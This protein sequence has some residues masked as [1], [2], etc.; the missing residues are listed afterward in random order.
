MR[1]LGFLKWNNS[2][3]LCIDWSSKRPSQSIYKINEIFTFWL[4]WSSDIAIRSFCFLFFL[5]PNDAKSRLRSKNSREKLTLQVLK[6]MRSYAHR[7]LVQHVC[8]ILCL[9]FNGIKEIAR[10]FTSKVNYRK[11]SQ[12][13]F[14]LNMLQMAP[15][16]RSPNHYNYQFK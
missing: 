8:L 3:E 11:A 2:L 15:K 16:R 13:M 9:I 12:I 5:R 4:Q 6:F 7:C 1:G 10:G 14:K